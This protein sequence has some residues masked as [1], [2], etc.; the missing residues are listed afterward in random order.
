VEAKLLSCLRGKLG[1]R[2]GVKGALKYEA[3]PQPSSQ[4]DSKLQNKEEEKKS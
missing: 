1:G 2:G 3:H 4:R